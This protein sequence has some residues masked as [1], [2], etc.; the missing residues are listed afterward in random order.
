MKKIRICVLVLLVT[1][2]GNRFAMA[3][4]SAAGEAAKKESAAKSA[5]QGTNREIY[6][7]I[8]S[9]K[10]TIVTLQTRSGALVQV[11]AKPAIAAERSVTL[12]VGHAIDV[13]GTVDKAGV[14]HAEILQKA[15]DSPT[16]WPAD[17]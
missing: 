4:A 16:I 2:S 15:K 13:K 17:R 7:K 8:Q 14:F 3:Q 11:D 12:I 9:V 5:Q 6:G 1:A 10:G